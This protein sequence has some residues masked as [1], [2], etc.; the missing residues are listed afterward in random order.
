LNRVR[1]NRQYQLFRVWSAAA[2]ET[3]GENGGINPL[4]ISGLILYSIYFKK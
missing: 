2:V 4:I 3:T 1:K